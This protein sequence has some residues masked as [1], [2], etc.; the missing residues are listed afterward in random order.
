VEENRF[1][2]KN[3]TLTWFW[4]I[5]PLGEKEKESS[6]MQEYEDGFVGVD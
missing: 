1:G 4:H 2:K 5:G 3:D 6:W